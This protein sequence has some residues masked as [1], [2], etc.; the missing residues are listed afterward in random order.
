VFSKTI[1]QEK[2]LKHIKQIPAKD[3]PNSLRYAFA[4][5]TC[6]WNDY[7]P[8]PL[9]AVCTVSEWIAILFYVCITG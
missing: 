8:V 5:A 6:H 4:F 2:F 1:Q 9:V 7:M 3:M